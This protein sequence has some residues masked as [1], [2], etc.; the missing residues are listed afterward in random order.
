MLSVLENDAGEV[1]EVVMEIQDRNA[2]MEAHLDKILAW[3]ERNETGHADVSTAFALLDGISARLKAYV[4]E[5]VRYTSRW[6]DDKTKIEDGIAGM[7]EL[8]ETYEHFLHAYDRLIVEAA[9]R[10]AVKKQMERVVEEAQSKLDAMYEDDFAEREHFR[11]EQGDFLPADIWTGLSALPPRF[12]FGRVDGVEEDIIP[13]L[14]RKTVDEAL[15]RL[16]RGMGQ[17]Q[18]R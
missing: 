8:C 11:S 15:K 12:G 16:K 9:R 18:S 6:V 17:D 7:E 2:E 10:R 1:D 3:R 4:A 14:P 5:S 13:E